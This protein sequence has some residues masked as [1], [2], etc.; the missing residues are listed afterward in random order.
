MG[1]GK[2]CYSLAEA[3]RVLNLAKKN[4]HRSTFHRDKRPI[5]KYWCKECKAY[6]VTSEFKKSEKKRHDRPLKV[7]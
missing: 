4:R 3:G 2:K 6:H 7:L 5:R 1:C